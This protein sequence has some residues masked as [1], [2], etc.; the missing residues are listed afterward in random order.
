MKCRSVA[1]VWS[2]TPPSHRVTAA[3]VLHRHPTLYTGGSDGSLIW[4]NLH[5]SDSTSEL[6]PIAM[7]CGHATPIA[8]LAICDPLAVSE[9][10]KRDAFSNAELE[11]SSGALISA[12]VDGMLC[13]WS[14]SSGHC[15]RRRR[16]PPWVGS[17]S[18]VRTLPSNPRYVC[19]AC[20]FV[21][22]VHLNDHQHSVESSEVLVDREAAHHKKPS[23][24]TL[25]VVD[26]CTLSIVQTVF[27]GNLSIASL[28]FMDVVLL[29]EGEGT[30]SVVMADS[31]GRM[32][33][34][35]LPKE[36]VLDKEGG[37]GLSTSTQMENT[38]CA[39][40]LSEGGQVMSTAAC[41]NVIA[42]VLKSRCVFRL[43]PTGTMLGEIS[44]ADNNFAG[45]ESNSTESH[46]VGG[47]FLKTENAAGLEAQEPHE[48]FSRT[49]AVWNNKGLLF[50]YLI[51]YVS[52]TFKCERLCEI[53]ASSYPVDVR[54]S[55]SFIQL[56]HYILRI[57]SVCL[58][59]GEQI[60]WKPH[61][62]IWSSC[63]KHDDHGNLCLSFKLHGVG[64]SFVDWT[65]NSM[66]SDQ[67]EVMQTKLTS[68]HPFTSSSGNSQSSH[69]EIDSLGLVN[70]RGV[71]SSSMVISETFFVPNAVVYG[72]YSGEIEMVR[73]DLLEGLASIGGSPRHKP[74]SHMSRQLF[75][76]HTGAVLCLAAHRMVGDAKGWSFNQVLVSGSMDCTVRIWDLDTGNLITVMHQHVGPVR[77]II[78]PPDH[79]YRPWSDCFLSVGEDSCVALTSLETLRAER[80]FPGHPSYP[81]KV[82]WDSGRG[83]IACLCRNHSG[84]S[85]TIDILYIW[86][87]K[88]GARERVLRGTA[89][90]SMF[91]HFCQGISMKSISGSAL[92]EN[93][94]FSSLL[95]PV[96]EDGAFTHSHLNSS[97]KL[98]SSSNMAPGNTA[99]SNTSRLSKGDS[100]KLFPAPQ[101]AIQSRKHPITCSCPFPGIAALSFDLASLVF[102]YQ[103]D[104]LIANS[105]DKKED[106]YVKG[107]ESETPSPRRMPVDNGSSAHSSSNDPVQ[108]IEWIKTLEECLLR[109]SL[110]FLHL[111][112]VDFELDNLIIADLKLKRPDN[113]FLASGFQGDK[114]SLTLT[115]PNLNAIL[116]LWRMPSEFSAIRSLTMVSLAQRM[117]SLSHA[118]SNACSAL[119]AF[120]TRNFAE[121][122]S[123][124]KPPLLQLLV[125]FWQD[126][127][128]HVRMAARTLFHCAA[129]RA[130]PLPLCCQKAN[131]HLN[132]SSLNFPVETE[133]VNPNLEEASTN[134]LSSKSEELHILAWLESFEMQ[135]WISCVGGTSQDAMT[136]HIIV[137]AALAIWYPSLVKSCLA[138][139]VVHPLMKL[140]MAV[141]EKYSSTA[142]ELLAEGMEGTW[143][144]CISSEIP[145][146]IGDIFFQI[147]CVSGPSASS[148]AQNLA[149][150]V[151]LQDTLVGVL[152]PSL[153][154]ADV[155]GFLAVMES[156]IWSTASDSPVH[157]V[158]LMTLMRVVRGSPRHLAQYLDKVIDVILQTVDPSNSVMRKTCFQSSMSALK[159]VARAFPMVALSDTWTKLAVGDVIGEKNNASIRVYDMQSIMKIKILDASGPPGL[160]NLLAA[161]SE[162]K[163]VTAISALNFTP[164]GEGLLAFSEHGLMIRWWSLGS[165]WWEKL[166]RNLVPVQCTKLIFVPPWEGFSPNS[167]RSSIMARIMGHDGQSNIQENAQ[168]LSQ[169]DNLKLLIHNLELSY[170]LEWIGERKVRLTRHGHELGTFQL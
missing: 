121:K 49:F 142:A 51:S 111:W 98:V 32:Q 12:C 137:A 105:C 10:D 136:S 42:F 34:V 112:N 107:Q 138:K 3:A 152:L 2:A 120:Y 75:L 71:V 53:P 139:L 103:K 116:E 143:K 85:D 154:M 114:G 163:L 156:Q 102:P 169:A 26:S 19:V 110:G 35:S 4:W 18:M 23:K 162:M 164:D 123:D 125:S 109:F 66:P 144:E 40:P 168:G 150:P 45:E 131:G 55:V 48:V 74:K 13:V 134:L 72:F 145:R 96:T 65:A 133:H 14:R 22:N 73:F 166:S 62:T 132:L 99:E 41:E 148:S 135:D 70:K 104:D 43:L 29:P 155:P 21:D 127:S 160:P 100:E 77:Q 87:V 1:C 27:H 92:N 57:E 67:T 157:L 33:M 39:K 140:V 44:F 76:G 159:E 167:M 130:I 91:D 58:I 80:I 115:F 165:V 147:E 69:A 68:S 89:S 94:S 161:S 88:S 17:P 56:S 30:H 101:I 122:I 90:H 124:I 61:I 24:C 129:S 11:S 9:S 158:S 31:F 6:V 119:A 36:P 128:E 113:F 146:L 170:Q 37:T 38:V 59:A 52:D 25:V 117:I 60:R 97:D 86:D 149:V 151:G 47:I 108:E 64:R 95:L 82:V 50:V 46:F 106:N 28:K 81:A 7:L 93:T 20:C 16:L 79:T 54:L 8:D 84:T 83:Y 63:G 118:S 78:L 141:N 15:R 153:A 126:E 5:S